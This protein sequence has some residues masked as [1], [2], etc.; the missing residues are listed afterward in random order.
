MSEG[1][2]GSL[3]VFR[4]VGA[5]SPTESEQV[6][7]IHGMS[8]TTNHSRGPTKEAVLPVFHGQMDEPLTDCFNINTKYSSPTG[9]SLDMMNAGA[10][11]NSLQ[12]PDLEN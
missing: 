12:V 11:V 9:P 3:R 8:S 4:I 10:Y 1:E 2:Y 7:L 5:Q 6:R